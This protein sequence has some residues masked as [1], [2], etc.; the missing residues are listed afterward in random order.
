[1]T[2][3][4]SALL[5]ICLFFKIF[6]IIIDFIFM[7]FQNLILDFKLKKLEKAIEKREKNQ[8]KKES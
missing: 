3:L 8:K 1:M 5:V 4:F 2:E 6:E 7:F